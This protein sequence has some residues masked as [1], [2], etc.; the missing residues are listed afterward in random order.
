MN[1]LLIDCGQF[2]SLIQICN[3]KV[4]AV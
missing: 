1:H 2:D 3:I 4:S